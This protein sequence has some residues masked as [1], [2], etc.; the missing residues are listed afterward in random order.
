ML[1]VHLEFTAHQALEFRSLL[2]DRGFDTNQ[3]LV[4]HIHED[5]IFT[6]RWV[7]VEQLKGQRVTT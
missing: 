1:R 6:E 4:V 2:D 3:F 5:C 7:T